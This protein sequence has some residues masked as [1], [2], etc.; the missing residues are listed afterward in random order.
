MEKRYNDIPDFSD[1]TRNIL[2]ILYIRVLNSTKASAGK[3]MNLFTRDRAK[4]ES[5]IKEAI[6]DEYKQ[7]QKEWD[8]LRSKESMKETLTNDNFNLYQR[9]ESLWRDIKALEA[10]KA[11]LEMMFT[12]ENSRKA[13]TLF[14]KIV[15]EAQNS[16][17]RQ[18]AMSAAG[19]I[20]AA[21]FGMKTYF[22]KNTE[23][24]K[25]E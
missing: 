6:G 7:F 25:E 1:A 3:M 20:V 23:T 22:G 16:Y 4:V 14:H 2:D 11:E 15:D 13:Y 21:M 9:R 5:C 10:K 24:D 18:R 17:E 12:D 8:E 19:A